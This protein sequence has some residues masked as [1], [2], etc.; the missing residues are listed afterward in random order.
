LAFSTPP[1]FFNTSGGRP[2]AVAMPQELSTFNDAVAIAV[3]NCSANMDGLSVQ[4]CVQ[5]WMI[6]LI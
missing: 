1:G 3:L 4:A 5:A 6:Q 2:R